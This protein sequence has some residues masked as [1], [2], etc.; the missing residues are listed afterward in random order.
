MVA[1]TLKCTCSW[2]EAWHPDKGD[3]HF[4]DMAPDRDAWN[5]GHAP[6]LIDAGAIRLCRPANLENHA[7]VERHCCMANAEQYRP[8][9]Q[10]HGM[11]VMA[12][13][14]TLMQSSSPSLAS[15]PLRPSRPLPRRAPPATGRA[16]AAWSASGER[17]HACTSL[18]VHATRATQSLELPCKA[19]GS[20]S[21]LCSS[22]SLACHDAGDSFACSKKWSPSWGAAHAGNASWATRSSCSSS[23]TSTSG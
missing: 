18:K 15:S 3:I 14:C 9:S 23:L 12:P 10:P 16:T 20:L 7:L 8:T 6:C 22:G 2:E 4:Y 5:P 13:G 1:L 21:L 11:T 17:L 19:A